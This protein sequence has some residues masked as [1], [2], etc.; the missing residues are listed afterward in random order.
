M[1]ELA[2]LTRL[3]EHVCESNDY[4]TTVL[5][6]LNNFY[7]IKELQKHQLQLNQTSPLHLPARPSPI[8]PLGSSH[9]SVIR[10]H[11]ISSE[12]DEREVG[13]EE[14]EDEVLSGEET[15]SR[16]ARHSGR[17][18]SGRISTRQSKRRSV[19]SSSNIATTAAAAAPASKR[20]SRRRL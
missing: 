11:D 10:S 2:D 14:D 5:K 19:A 17:L 8:I 6:M 9:K 15:T 18:L 12:V 4:P 1:T 3:V 13:D 7:D 20:T 16:I